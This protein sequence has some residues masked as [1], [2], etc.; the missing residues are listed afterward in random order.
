MHMR[1]LPVLGLF[2]LSTVVMAV[3]QHI[4]VVDMGVPG[5]PMVPLIERVVRVVV[6]DMEMIV[7]VRLSQVGVLRL[8]ARTLCV[9]SLAGA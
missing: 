5:S 2:L 3:R 9:L 1:F 8:L 7:N 4:V 6:G